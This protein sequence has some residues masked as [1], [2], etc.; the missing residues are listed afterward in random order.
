MPLIR[1]VSR[2]P[3]TSYLVPSPVLTRLIV[4]TRFADT[5]PRP[6][7]SEVGPMASDRPRNASTAQTFVVVTRIS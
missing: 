4:A 5:V 2:L 3:Q 7:S 6:I 1:L